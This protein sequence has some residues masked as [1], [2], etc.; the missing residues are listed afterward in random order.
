MVESGVNWEA[1]EFDYQHKDISWYW[2]A[3]I[4]GVILTAVALW[5][6]N[7]LFAIF[8]AIAIVMIVFWGRQK[9]RT[10]K[11]KLDDKGLYIDEKFYSFKGF[12][13]F[14]TDEEILVFKNKGRFSP[15][16]KIQISSKDTEAIQ[17]YLKPILSEIEY[18][19]SLTEVLVKWLG[20]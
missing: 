18:E 9:P 4:I 10:I 20:F 7:L 19:E 14:Y 12:D 1:P 11:Y 13:G 17:K 6:K 15:Y 5:Q 16:L 8:I 3:V 2:L